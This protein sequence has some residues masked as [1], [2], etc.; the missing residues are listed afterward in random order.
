MSYRFS[1]NKADLNKIAVGA[2][3]A[4]VGA[5]LTYV[6]ETITSVDFGQWTPIVVAVWSILANTVRKFVVGEVITT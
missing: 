6:S 1:L 2:G 4:V 5:L 3:V